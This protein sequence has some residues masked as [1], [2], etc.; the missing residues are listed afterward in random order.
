MAIVGAAAFMSASGSIVLFV[1]AMLV[2]VTADTSFTIPIAIGAIVG[3]AVNGLLRG[4]GLYHTLMRLSNLP[5]LGRWH[6]PQNSQPCLAALPKDR[7]VTIGPSQAE[8]ESNKLRLGN[9]LNT[10]MEQ[11][12]P[13]VI[14]ADQEVNSAASQLFSELRDCELRLRMVLNR[15]GAATMGALDSE[16]TEVAQA[17]KALRKLHEEEFPSEIIKILTEKGH[18]HHAFPVVNRLD[19]LVGLVRRED[20]QDLLKAYEEQELTDSESSEGS[21]PYVEDYLR[22]SASVPVLSHD[23]KLVLTQL[24]DVQPYEVHYKFPIYRVH[25]L[26][27][28]IMLRHLVVVDSDRRPVGVITRTSLLDI[29]TEGLARAFG[30]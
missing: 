3:R 22:S 15:A 29:T 10:L 20:L 1:I 14:A 11:L 26:F 6:G 21:Q 12:R 9:T 27:Q 5:F 2:E 7:R 24:M 18:Y 28:Q 4:H 13:C 8:L 17:R 19:T 25:R 30:S 16:S 23:G